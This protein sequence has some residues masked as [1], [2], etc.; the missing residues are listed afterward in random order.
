MGTVITIM[1]LV[2]L[3]DLSF[4]ELGLGLLHCGRGGACWLPQRPSFPSI[5]AGVMDSMLGRGP[6]KSLYDKSMDE[7]L[8]NCSKEFGMVPVGSCERGLGFP[9][10]SA[11]PAEKVFL[12][13]KSF[14]SSLAESGGTPSCQSN[15]GLIHSE[16]FCRGLRL[17]VWSN[18]P[19]QL[20]CVYSMRLMSK[21]V[22]LP[23]PA[24]LILLMKGK[25]PAVWLTSLG[26]TV[27]FPHL[28]LCQIGTFPPVWQDFTIQV[29]TEIYASEVRANIKGLWNISCKLVSL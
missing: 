11:S 18:L 17:E 16:H 12:L 28:Q 26:P 13:T 10:C 24:L 25:A 9:A 22:R 3:L 21:E 27:S 1:V 14:C 15:I 23:K 7:R 29:V 8:C 5:E 4:L 2:L 6:S 20:E 19:V